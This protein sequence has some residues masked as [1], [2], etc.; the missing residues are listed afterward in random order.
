MGMAAWDAKKLMNRMEDDGKDPRTFLGIPEKGKPMVDMSWEV[1][2]ASRMGFIKKKKGVRVKP[3]RNMIPVWLRGPNYDVLVKKIQER[4]P[5]V[6][7]D[8]SVH[9]RAC[10]TDSGDGKNGNT[11]ALEAQA[12]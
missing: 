5:E 4:Y 1:G 9:A 8:A 3:K 12:C 2:M 6:I 10:D 7:E 11:E